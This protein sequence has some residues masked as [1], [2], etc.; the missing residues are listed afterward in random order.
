MRKQIVTPEELAPPKGFNHGLTVENGELLFLAGQD[1]SGPDGDIVAPGDLVSQFEQVMANLAAVVEEAGG[2]SADIVK[3][4]VFV[5]DRD[6][7]RDNLEEIGEI[8]ADY[9]E[10]YPAM[11][12]FEV[13]GFFK[14]DALIEME[15]FAV[16]DPAGPDDDHDPGAL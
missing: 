13:S 5:A 8:F 1:A 6:A 2:S 14:E 10:E 3:L 4:N 12:L 7:Y 16:I 11:A 9:V 15:G